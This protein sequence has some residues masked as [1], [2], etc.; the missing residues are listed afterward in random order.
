MWRGVTPWLRILTTKLFILPFQMYRTYLYLGFGSFKY[1][2][3][4]G[5]FNEI[6]WSFNSKVSQSFAKFHKVSEPQKMGFFLTFKEF[7]LRPETSLKLQSE[8]ITKFHKFT[9][10]PKRYSWIKT[11]F[12]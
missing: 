12:F 8:I 9:E 11:R 4:A 7:E 10:M 6:Y 1:L 2:E 5:G 3:I